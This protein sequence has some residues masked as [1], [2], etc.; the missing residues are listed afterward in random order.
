MI[1]K[2]ISI[3]V[4]IL[5]LTRAFQATYKKHW[6]K[7]RKRDDMKFRSLFPVLR[8]EQEIILFKIA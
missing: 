8:K 4:T 6:T 7:K 5:R 1:K 3:M 2:I